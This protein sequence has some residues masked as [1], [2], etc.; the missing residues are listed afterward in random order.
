M[1]LSTWV[2]DLVMTALTNFVT[3][4]QVKVDKKGREF[5]SFK[6][7][8][9][10][11]SVKSAVMY[12]TKKGDVRI[13]TNVSHRKVSGQRFNKGHNFLLKAVNDDE[14][15]VLH[16]KNRAGFVP[17]AEIRNLSS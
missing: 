9:D 10:K 2:W 5:V 3:G 17:K 7:E 14:F 6:F 15:I 13:L 4:H 11:T 16:N 1:D 12:V 8:S